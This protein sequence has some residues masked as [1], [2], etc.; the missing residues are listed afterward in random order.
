MSSRQ[1]R[2][3]KGRQ[4]ALAASAGHPSARKWQPGYDAP[5][6]ARH[7]PCGATTVRDPEDP[8]WDPD[9]PDTYVRA[10]CTLGQTHKGW[11]V[12]VDG[13]AWHPEDEQ[14]HVQLPTT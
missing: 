4:R 3:D 14:Q 12:S 10:T 9:A 13:Y 8:R 6:E 5:G 2:R 1:A 11:H 7:A